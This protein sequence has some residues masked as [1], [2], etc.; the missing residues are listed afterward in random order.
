MIERGFA[1]QASATAPTARSWFRRVGRRIADAMPSSASTNTGYSATSVSSVPLYS[2]DGTKKEKA[3]TA[4]AARVSTNL[5]ARKYAGN[6][7]T[8]RSTELTTFAATYARDGSP[9][10]AHAGEMRSG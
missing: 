10:M 2:I 8:P 7:V 4:T 6:A 1:L 3:A 5:R 9:N